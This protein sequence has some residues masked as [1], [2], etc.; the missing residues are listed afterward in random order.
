LQLEFVGDLNF[1]LVD[2]IAREKCCE[3]LMSALQQRR[4]ARYVPIKG[5]MPSASV[6]TTRLTT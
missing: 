2:V 5:T 6:S 4:L 1:D 3:F